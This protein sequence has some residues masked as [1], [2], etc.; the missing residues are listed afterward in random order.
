MASTGFTSP[1]NHG[2]VVI[3][4]MRDGTKKVMVCDGVSAG[5][6]QN[7]YAAHFKC[8]SVDVDS[9]IPLVTTP[10]GAY[11]KRVVEVYAERPGVVHVRA[12]RRGE[13]PIMDTIA[14][15][16]CWGDTPAIRGQ[17][18]IVNSPPPPPIKVAVDVAAQGAAG[19]PDGSATVH[20]TVRCTQSTKLDVNGTVCRLSSPSRT[21]LLEDKPTQAAG[22][23]TARG[24]EAA[25]Q[26]IPDLGVPPH[27]VRD[28]VGHSGIEV[29]MTRLFTSRSSDRQGGFGR[30]GAGQCRPGLDLE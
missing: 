13:N 18:H 1:T 24:P 8:T 17:L 4:D 20:G 28:M 16:T 5:E 9:D 2:F 21:P 19:A 29:T 26:P 11:S 6:P 23:A 7:V 12:L 3:R 27:I 14:R 10:A 15:A 22:P 25:R 30:M